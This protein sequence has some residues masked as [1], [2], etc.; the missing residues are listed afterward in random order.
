VWL[1]RCRLFRLAI[2]YTETKAKPEK[3]TSSGHHAL[4]LFSNL[5]RERSI[6]LPADE[7]VSEQ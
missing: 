1:T 3:P 7:Q 4:R 6:L 2:H 5:M